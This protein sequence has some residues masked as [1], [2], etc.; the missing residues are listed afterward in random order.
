MEV[1][2]TVKDEHDELFQE[3]VSDVEEV[4]EEYL[5]PKLKTVVVAHERDE[6]ECLGEAKN[7][8]ERKFET[9]DFCLSALLLLFTRSFLP[10]RGSVLNVESGDTRELRSREKVK[11]RET[12]FS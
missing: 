10:T 11:V 3:G 4:E 8:E 9:M 7:S 5:E 1:A 2:G 12:L 6:V